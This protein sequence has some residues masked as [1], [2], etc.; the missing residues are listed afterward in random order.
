M[1]PFAT[2]ASASRTDAI[3]ASNG[4]SISRHRRRDSRNRRAAPSGRRPATRRRRRRARPTPGSRPC[5]TPRR[6]PRAPP[7]RPGRRGVAERLRDLGLGSSSRERASR[8]QVISSRLLLDRGRR[9]SGTAAPEQ[10]RRPGC[11]SSPSA[12]ALRRPPRR[13]RGRPSASGPRPTRG[14]PRRRPPGGTISARPTPAAPPTR[15]GPGTREPHE[16]GPV[17]AA[18]PGKPVMS[19]RSHQRFETSAHSVPR[20]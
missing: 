6:S 13:R 14:T 7:P 17:D 20:R 9:G 2:C 4:A 3:A 16:L 15:V 5:R 10:E 1:S 11:G 18:D 12:S 19:C 8:F